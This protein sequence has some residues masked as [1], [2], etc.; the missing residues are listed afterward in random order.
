MPSGLP[1]A[2]AVGDLNGDG[3]LDAVAVAG[4][5]SYGAAFLG[6]GAG[7]LLGESNF[8]STIYWS[9][10]RAVTVGDFIG[11]GIPDL[12]VSGWAVEIFTGRGD[13]TFG[14]PI[15][16]SATGFEHTGVAVANFNGDGLLD[17]VTS[18]ADTGTVS[19]LLGNG[20][21]TLTYAG[22]CAVC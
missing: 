8:S 22:A 4:D 19:E 20:N 3:N 5:S 17:A 18:D 11:D 10:A 21:G 16:H 2:L 15:A 7:G 9:P 14:E 6:N 12:V 1:D 13:G